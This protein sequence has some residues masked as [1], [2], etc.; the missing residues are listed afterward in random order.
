MPASH[1]PQRDQRQRRRIVT[2]SPRKARN[3]AGCLS[4]SGSPS[5]APRIG[6]FSVAIQI[7][8]SSPGNPTER[9]AACHP[10]SPNGPPAG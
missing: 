10:T 9:N 1:P 4:G 3:G 2:S 6:S 7:A 8:T 5:T